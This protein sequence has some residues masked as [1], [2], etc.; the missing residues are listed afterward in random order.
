MTHFEK[1]RLKKKK[2]CRYGTE[3]PPSYFRKFD[4]DKVPRIFN[5]ALKILCYGG[6]I[7][8]SSSSDGNYGAEKSSSVVGE[9]FRLLTCQ[10]LFFDMMGEYFLIQVPQMALTW[11]WKYFR[12]PYCTLLRILKNCHRQ[13]HIHFEKDLESIGVFN[14]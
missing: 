1:T 8:N 5:M 3:N 11:H 4:K 14:A 10:C 13:I 2:I 12:L 7:V 9:K 6:E